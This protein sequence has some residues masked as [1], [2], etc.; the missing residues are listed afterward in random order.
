MLALRAMGADVGLSGTN[1]FE[2]G[3]AD[4]MNWSE[5]PP[6]AFRTGYTRTTAVA[7]VRGRANV[8]P[9]R[10]DSGGGWSSR[11]YLPGAQRRR[12][13]PRADRQT[14]ISMAA[15]S[16]ERIWRVWVVDAVCADALAAR[17]ATAALR[18]GHPAGLDGC[19][20]WWRG[21]GGRTWC[22]LDR[23]TARWAAAI[24]KRVLETREKVRL[25]AHAPAR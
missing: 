16:V 22:V 14:P 5:C 19:S 24:S 17:G 1:R 21:N 6:R 25:S 9:M 7:S 20:I 18:S 15:I 4:T 13:H 10:G 3:T 23:N 8:A 11:S 12:R 2:F